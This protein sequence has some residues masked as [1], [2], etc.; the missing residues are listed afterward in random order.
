MAIFYG[1]CEC[2]GRYTEIFTSNNFCIICARL[3]NLE[4]VV[5]EFITKQE[6]NQDDRH[7]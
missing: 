3:K 2:C 6:N 1:T 5:Q 7:Q 4:E